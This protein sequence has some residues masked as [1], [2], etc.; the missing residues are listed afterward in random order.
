M[1][2][3]GNLVSFLINRARS[4]IYST[5]LPPALAEACIRAIDIVDSGSLNLR[6]RLWKNRQRLYLGIRNLGYD[7]L[8]S[9]TPIIP[10]F[11]GGTK[12]ALKIG[13]YLYREKIFAPAIRPPAVPEGK[14]RIRFSV[15]AAHTNEDIDSVLESLKKYRV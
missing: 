4:F 12:T 5:S 1:A 9:E 8:D 15:T 7:T 3:S 13:S 6:K 10:L 2:G 14:C 11:V